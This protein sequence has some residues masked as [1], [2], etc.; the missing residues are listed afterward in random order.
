MEGENQALQAVLRHTQTM[1]LVCPDKTHTC[2]MKKYW[3][4][5]LPVL[6]QLTRR[7]LFP[8]GYSFVLGLSFWMLEQ[9]GC[10]GLLSLETFN[11]AKRY[12]MIN[13][14]A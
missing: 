2:K 3:K 5:A 11:S 12:E 6:T 7:T 14:V 9:L 13:S 4:E 1:A 10:R 8:R